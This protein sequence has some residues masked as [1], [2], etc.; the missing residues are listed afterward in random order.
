MM[1]RQRGAGG[2]LASPRPCNSFT[3]RYDMGCVR[4][5]VVQV[6]RVEVHWVPQHRH[7]YA[8]SVRAGFGSSL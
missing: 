4:R 6:R 8:G 7:R 1:E 5:G 2:E 3:F